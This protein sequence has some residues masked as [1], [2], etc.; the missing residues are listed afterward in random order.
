MTTLEVLQGA[1]DLLSSPDRWCKKSIAQDSEGG[2]CGPH[3]KK[4]VRWC[5]LGALVRTIGE[6]DGWGAEFDS[7]VKVLSGSDTHG[8]ELV[9]LFNDKPDTAHGDVVAY[10]DQAIE[11]EKAK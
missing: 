1:R 4:A 2:G 11:R 9:S 10:F 6:K 3:L 5:A 8:G 7:A